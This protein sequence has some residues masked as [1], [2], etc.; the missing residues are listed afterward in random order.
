[1]ALPPP[2]AVPALH[3]THEPEDTYWPVLHESTQAYADVEPAGDV[4]PL[5]QL[6]Q[7]LDP[8]EEKVL[9]GQA[10]QEPEE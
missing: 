10:K 4:C 6:V 8:L 1:M 5:G 9:T 7:E 3:A 2:P